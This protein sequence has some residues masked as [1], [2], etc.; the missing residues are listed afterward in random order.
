MEFVWRF[1]D[2]E[3]N[4]QL[5]MMRAQSAGPETKRIGVR[6]KAALVE[7]ESE[8]H[9]LRAGNGR[10]DTHP[11]GRL[12]RSIGNQAVLRTLSRTTPAIQTKLTVNQPGDQYEEEAD[13]VADHVMRMP[14][15]QAL[16]LNPATPHVQ[17]KCSCAGRRRA[18][19][20]S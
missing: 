16:S 19:N 7:S 4:G 8:I 6:A 10:N 9:P 5:D 15:A 20:A 2:Q 3:K 11:M 1:R 18:R 12:H 17:R 14:N 13:R